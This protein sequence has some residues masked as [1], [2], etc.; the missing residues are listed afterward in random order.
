MNKIVLDQEE[1]IVVDQDLDIVVLPHQ[2]KQI[3]LCCENV[4]ARINYQ[5][6]EDSILRVY[7]YSINSSADVH[8]SLK[9]KRAEIIYS[10]STINDQ[11]EKFQVEVLHDASETKSIMES[12]GINA[13][14]GSLLFDI[15]PFVSC[16]ANKCICNQENSI[17][18][19]AEGR[20]SIRPNLFIDNYDVV[21][22]HSA[23]IGTFKEEEIF[24]LMKSGLSRRSSF[25]LLM[26]HFLV[27]DIEKLEEVFPRYLE[28][29]EC[30]E[31]E[32]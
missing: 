20:S 14:N 2:E 28:K 4:D 23:Y 27:K 22:N 7:H 13:G 17:I 1:V 24:Y 25:L 10:Y 12:H 29:I 21:S 6:G 3:Y 8:I 30:I 19:L 31:K 5:V 32:V 16:D 9:E 26:R 11:E 15:N 18:N